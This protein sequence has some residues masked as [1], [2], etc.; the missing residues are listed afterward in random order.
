M[1][2]EV[3]Y[4]ILGAIAVILGGI[5]C[6]LKYAFGRGVDKHKFDALEDMVKSMPCEQHKEHQNTNEKELSVVKTECTNNINQTIEHK[7]VIKILTAD[8]VDIKLDI[9][10][11][12]TALSSKSKKSTLALAQKQS[13]RK[14]TPLGE[15]IYINSGASKFYNEHKDLFLRLLAEKQP[16]TLL[17]VE[18]L[19]QMTLLDELSNIIFVP[20]KNWVYNSPSYKLE[21]DEILDVS[22]NDICF[23]ISLKLRD[24]FIAENRGLFAAEIAASTSSSK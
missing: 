14:L 16:A 13:P 12:K 20:L 7:E 10:E 11:I 22:I 8:L 23:L 2:A 15:E 19:A 3:I 24:D 1:S 17:D 6:M 9:R 4:S 18:S 21:N 5:W